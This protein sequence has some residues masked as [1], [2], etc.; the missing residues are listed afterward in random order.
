MSTLTV[1]VPSHRNTPRGA[2]LVGWLVDAAGALKAYR[3]ARAEERRLRRRAADREAVFRMARELQQ[4][5]P[6]MASDL[7]AAAIRDCKWG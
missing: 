4:V 3:R 5:D 2:K 6:G 7:Y 1:V